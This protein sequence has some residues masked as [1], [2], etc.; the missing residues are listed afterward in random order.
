MFWAVVVLLGVM[1]YLA[2]RFGAFEQEMN[3]E[4]VR[5]LGG[6]ALG[7]FVIS[8]VVIASNVFQAFVA[9]GVPPFSG[10]SDPVRFSLNPKYIIWSSEGTKKIYSDFSFLG[11]RDVKAPDY[12]FAP[13]EKKLGI[14]FDNESANSPFVRIDKS[15]IYNL[16]KSCPLRSL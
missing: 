11:K 8:A 12:A 13:N 7:A 5:K 10:Q 15:C 16:R 3:G 1:F 4:K 2:P 9:T 6:F 14:T